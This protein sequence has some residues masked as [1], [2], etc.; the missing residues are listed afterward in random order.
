MTHGKDY[1]IKLAEGKEY[2]KDLPYYLGP[3]SGFED[4]L[5]RWIKQG[6]IISCVREDGKE[7]YAD[8]AIDM[9]KFLDGVVRETP[10]CVK[11]KSAR[12]GCE[13]SD[14]TK[15]T[16]EE[17]CKS[18][19][20]SNKD[21]PACKCFE[22]SIS[23]GMLVKR[24]QIN[25]RDVAE[26]TIK[27]HAICYMRE[28]KGMYPLGKPNL[29]GRSKHDYL[30]RLHGEKATRELNT[31]KPVAVDRNGNAK[32]NGNDAPAHHYVFM[33]YQLVSIASP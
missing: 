1:K 6:V 10:N 16:A 9:T 11:C 26:K 28:K 5:R 2:G 25:F 18:Y 14:G 27:K 4:Y 3:P 29:S 7:L 21:H 12:E 32:G 15:L 19:A 33:G 23:V 20:V 30:V 13:L 31:G 24:L 22:H 17:V 8:V